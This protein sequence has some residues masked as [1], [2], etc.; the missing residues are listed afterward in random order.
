[1]NEHRYQRLLAH[2]DPVVREIGE[3]LRDGEVRP[4]DLLRDPEYRQV[5]QRG[6]ARLRAP[7]QR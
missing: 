1:M 2:D 6:L 4:R 7:D 5:I 3:Q